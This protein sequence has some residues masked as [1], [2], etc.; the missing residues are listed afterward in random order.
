MSY[1]VY[2][3]PS[4]TYTVGSGSSSNVYITSN[5]VDGTNISPSKLKVQGDAEFEGDLK[6]K[7]KSLKDSLD[8]IEERLAI[9]NPNEELEKRWEELRNL[10][11]QYMEMEAELIE[12]EK[13]WAILK[14]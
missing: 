3:P 11:K 14:K 10:R 5:G 6:L 1:A 4:T 2:Y 8:K 13:M 7:G 12:K 9:L